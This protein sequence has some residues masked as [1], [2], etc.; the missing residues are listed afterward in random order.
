MKMLRDPQVDASQMADVLG[1]QNPR[2]AM[3]VLRSMGETDAAV[4]EA[5]ANKLG[6]AGIMGGGQKLIAAQRPDI[7]QTPSF[8]SPLIPG[9]IDLNHRPHVKNPDGSVSSVR[10]VTFMDGPT[11]LLLPTVVGNKVVS[12]QEALA[13]YRKTGEFLGKFA[14]EDT[15]NAYAQDLHESQAAMTKPKLK[16]S[17]YRGRN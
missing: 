1:Q 15:A 2:T 13:H 10:S 6:M 16:A 9:N 14:S 4:Y 3:N 7:H 8:A 12:N 11:A 17:S 5:T